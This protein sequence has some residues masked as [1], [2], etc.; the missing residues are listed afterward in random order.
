M[1]RPKG[2]IPVSERR[3]YANN[4]RIVNKPHASMKPAE[5]REQFLIWGIIGE[6]RP[7]RLP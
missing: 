7:M 3:P 5:I 6:R 2:E 4:K 1:T